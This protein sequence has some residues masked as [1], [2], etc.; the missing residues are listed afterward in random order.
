M[1]KRLLMMVVNLNVWSGK[2]VFTVSGRGGEIGGGDV[3]G[4]ALGELW[5]GGKREGGWVVRCEAADRDR[6]WV[7][8]FVT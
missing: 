7:I 3:V 6:G 1:H 8:K 4:R 5:L 2:M